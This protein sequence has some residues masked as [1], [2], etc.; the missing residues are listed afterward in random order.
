M[1]TA[2][3]G[4]AATG[5]SG[6]GR[7][8]RA[9]AGS[10]RCASRLG[11]PLRPPTLDRVSTR[12]GWPL[13]SGTRRRSTYPANRELVTLRGTEAGLLDGRENLA[14]TAMNRLADETGRA[15]P[16]FRPR[17]AHGRPSSARAR[18]L[19]RGPGRRARRRQSSTRNV[20]CGLRA[21][22]ARLADGRP[23]RQRGR[24]PLW[25]RGACRARSR[26][27]RCNC[28]PTAGSIFAP[29]SSFRR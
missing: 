27:T 14:L 8:F 4:P 25:R 13:D 16:S 24:G 2:L 19:G 17:R 15:L 1:S 11:P 5:R 21:L 9:G 6:R 29:S 22:L 28:S 3:R 12:S 18:L 26:R 20:A 10:R 7:A 23:R